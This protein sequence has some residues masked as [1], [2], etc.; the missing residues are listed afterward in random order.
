MHR[1]CV[2]HT[3]PYHGR[4]HSGEGGGELVQG[5]G[6]CGTRVADGKGDELHPSSVSFEGRQ[7]WRVFYGLLLELNVAAEIYAEAN[8]DEDEG[9]F[10]LVDGG[11]VGGRECLGPL[12]HT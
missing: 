12:L 5:P 1:V 4:S 10:F 9:V 6:E 8:F 3:I 2:I 7:E 11:R